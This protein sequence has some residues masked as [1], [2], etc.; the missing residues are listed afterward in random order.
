M[1]IQVHGAEGEGLVL[2]LVV[3]T[4]GVASRRLRGP[5]PGDEKEEAKLER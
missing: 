3:A 2:A 1:N 4:V 5:V